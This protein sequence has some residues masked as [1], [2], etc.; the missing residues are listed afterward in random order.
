MKDSYDYLKRTISK[1]FNISEMT[2]SDILNLLAS[3]G[4]D[5]PY[6]IAEDGEHITRYVMYKRISEF[7]KH[8]KFQGDLLE[9]SG[10]NGAIVKMFDKNLISHT[11]T[12]FPEENAQN[13]S[14]NDNS[15]DFIVCD[16]VIEHVENPFEVFKEFYRVLRPGGWIFVTSC[17][18]EH[19][20]TQY[21]NPI[22]YWRFTPESLKFLAKD[23]NTIYQCEGWGNKEAFNTV[24]YG[25]IQKYLPVKDN[26]DLQK[27]VSY[28][29]PKYPLSVWI[30]AQ[31]EH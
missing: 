28:N 7:F 14:Y 21:D 18:L 6:P 11:T 13:L 26:I 30:I 23:F 16:Q 15:F 29:D 12:K 22:D 25:G 10:N 5:I 2:A 20:H 31:K 17:F 19:I 3:K 9:V 4:I 8:D 1:K 24:M 27:I